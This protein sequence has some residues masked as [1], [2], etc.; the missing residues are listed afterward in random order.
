MTFR[1][2]IIQLCVRS[3][4]RRRYLQGHAKGL[5]DDQQS[6][7]AAAANS[8]DFNQLTLLVVRRASHKFPARRVNDVRV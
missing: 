2:H 6:A 5:P 8:C 7:S 1:H 4:L 3:Q